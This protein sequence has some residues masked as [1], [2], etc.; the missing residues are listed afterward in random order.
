MID[1]KE[2]LLDLKVIKRNCLKSQNYDPES[3]IAYLVTKYNVE[4]DS[5]WK[6]IKELLTI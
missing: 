1:K 4:W 2:F 5:L 3:D 6:K